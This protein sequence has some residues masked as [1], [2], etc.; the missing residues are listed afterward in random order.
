MHGFCV[1]L[2]FR[3]RFG[4]STTSTESQSFF[5]AQSTVLYVFHMKSE[6]TASYTLSFLRQIALIIVDKKRESVVVCDI[7]VKCALFF[8]FSCFALR[9]DQMCVLILITLETVLV[10]HLSLFE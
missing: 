6:M 5:V 8:G 3:F 9:N 10:G 4:F 2:L 1:W 7:R